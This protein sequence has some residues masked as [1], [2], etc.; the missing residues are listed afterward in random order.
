MKDRRK[1]IGTR[2][3]VQE[4]HH[5]A[6]KGSGEGGGRKVTITTKAIRTMS[7]C[8]GICISGVDTRYRGTLLGNLRTVG[9]KK[10]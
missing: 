2:E 3:M 1:V 10:I 9:M 6:N 7:A 5:I 8:Q 4:T